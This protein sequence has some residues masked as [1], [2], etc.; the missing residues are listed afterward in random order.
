MPVAAWQLA[1]KKFMRW[2]AHL[3]RS[4]LLF[5]SSLSQ[6]L[7]HLQAICH[8]VSPLQCRFQIP[9]GVLPTASHIFQVL[10]QSPLREDPCVVSHNKGTR[11]QK[12]LSS[13]QVCEVLTGKAIQEEQNNSTLSTETRWKGLQSICPQD[14]HL[15]YALVRLQRNEP[16]QMDYAFI[17][18]ARPCKTAD[19]ASIGHIWRNDSKGPRSSPACSFCRQ[20]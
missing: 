4:L 3:R 6:Q 11:G 17:C 5:L 18:L 10:H 20:L 1:F 16:D 14:I 2:R 8:I 19:K 7:G 13:F 9:T 12:R 15:S